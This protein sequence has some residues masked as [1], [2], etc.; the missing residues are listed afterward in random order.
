MYPPSVVCLTDRPVSKPALPK[1]FVQSVSPTEFV[2]INQKSLEPAPYESVCPAII[3][4]PSLVWLTEY[5]ASGQFAPKVFV[6]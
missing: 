5:P 6:H 1:V 3:N 4:P 2:L